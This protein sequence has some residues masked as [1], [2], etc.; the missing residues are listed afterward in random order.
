MLPR[1]ATAALLGLLTFGASSPATRL[2]SVADSAIQQITAAELRA[3]VTVLASDRLSGRAVG[4]AGNREAEQYIAGVFRASGI[5]P[6]VPEY[7]QPV[8]VYQPRL[9]PDGRL[10]I[11]VGS[12]SALTDLRVGADFYPL[13]MSGEGPANGRMLFAGHG[14]S[15]PEAKHDDYAAIDARGA[16]VL[17]LDHAPERLRN[18][19]SLSAEEK[20]DVASVDRKVADARAHGAAGLVVVRTHMGDAKAL[21]PETSSARSASYRLLAP[22][23]S[24]PLAVAAISERAAAS[25]RK[26]IEVG[27]PVTAR[28]TP[29]VAVTPVIMHNVLAIVEGRQPSNEMVVVGAHLDHDGV[30]ESGRIYNGADDNASGTAAVL[31]IASAFSRAAAR[32]ERPARAVVFAL[33]NG[34]E[35]GSLGAEYYVK[36]PVPARRMI[37]NLNLDMVGRAE[38]IPDPNDARYHGFARTAAG[39]NG[40]VLHLLGYS[41]SPDLARIV[42]QANETIRLTIKEHYDEGSQ[43]LLRRSDNWPFL[44]HGIPAVFFTTGLHPDY[45]TPDDDTERLDFAKLE[46]IAELAG[47]AAWMTADGDAPRLKSK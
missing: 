46:R 42:E 3:H 39:Q 6:V 5:L 26:A 32:G 10:T 9:G 31:T 1:F 37:A 7:L 33:W 40:N 2:P 18:L 19:A 36:A 23:Q 25:V 43:G 30:D 20:A 8:A 14:I 17:V 15:A 41:Y 44:E 27:R 45:H 38:D 21:W 12:E 34:E 4:H 29:G 47:R 22:M 16:V 35:K 28:L 13:P 24:A 11:D